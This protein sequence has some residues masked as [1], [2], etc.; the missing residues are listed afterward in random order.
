MPSKTVASTT[1]SRPLQPTVRAVRWLYLT[2]F[3]SIAALT[4]VIRCEGFGLVV[5]LPAA[6]GVA[7]VAVSLV[8]SLLGRPCDA[9]APSRRAG[10]DRLRR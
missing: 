9:T 1:V 8:N 10:R 5:A 2:V 4:W 7:I 6:I 3:T